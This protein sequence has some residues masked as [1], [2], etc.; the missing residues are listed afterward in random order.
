M[1]LRNTMRTSES[2]EVRKAA[3]E[4]LRSVGPHV[5]GAHC[6]GQTA[7]DCMLVGCAGSGWRECLA[8]HNC[9]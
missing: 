6:G 2:E 4:G 8:S 9:S 7:P 5:A 3:Y 1:Q